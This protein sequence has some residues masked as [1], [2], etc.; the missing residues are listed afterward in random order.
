ML[1]LNSSKETLFKEASNSPT[2]KN[3]V[4]AKDWYAPDILCCGPPLR[5]EPLGQEDAPL[6]AEHVHMV[7]QRHAAAADPALPIVAAGWD[8]RGLRGF[9]LQM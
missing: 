2:W 3:E 8:C 6:V 5:E 1:P 7:G 4:P 9:T